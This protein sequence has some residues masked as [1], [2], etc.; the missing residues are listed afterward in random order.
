MGVTAVTGKVMPWQQLP[1]PNRIILQKAG[2]EESTFEPLFDEGIIFFSP[3][4]PWTNNQF[5]ARLAVYREF[6]GV[7]VWEW[8]C[9]GNDIVCFGKIKSGLF[10]F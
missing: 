2:E 8:I 4:N 6:E 7:D 10:Y 5:F 9:Y 3:I 1:L